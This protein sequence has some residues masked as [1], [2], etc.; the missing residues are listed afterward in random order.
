MI[1]LDG[2]LRRGVRVMP[3]K[4]Q[5]SFSLRVDE[6]QWSLFSAIATLKK[7]SAVD[8]LRKYVSEVVEEN[9]NMF[10]IGEIEK[11]RDE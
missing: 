10:N 2:Q 7:T 3:G 1:C 11:R 9:K 4:K 8:M 6:D 5:I